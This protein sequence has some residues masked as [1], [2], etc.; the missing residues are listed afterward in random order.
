MRSVSK[1]L[2]FPLGGVAANAN[3]RD[4]TYPSE[5]SI[6]STPMAVNVIGEC[7]FSSRFR[8]G[9]RPGL[10]PLDSAPTITKSADW[11]W[12]N[13]ENIVIGGGS[14][15]EVDVDSL[16]PALPVGYEIKVTSVEIR[17]DAESSVFYE[18]YINGISAGEFESLGSLR[19]ETIIGT[20]F[21][22]G[23]D[24]TFGD[25]KLVTEASYDL[26][27]D[28]S[29]EYKMPDGRR[30]VDQHAALSVTAAKGA[31]PSTIS[32]F[33][34]YRDRF[35]V[36]NGNAWYASRVS[37]HD[38]FDYGGEGDDPTRAL[39][40]QIAQAGREG[41]EIT[42]LIPVADAQ[43]YVATARRFG[44]FSGELTQGLTLLSENTGVISRDAWCNA[45]G[46]VYFLGA[47][48]LYGVGESG[49]MNVSQAIPEAFKGVDSAVLVYDPKRNGIHIFAERGVVHIDYFYDIANKAFWPMSYAATKRPVSG[50]AAVIDGENVVVFKCA[51]GAWRKWSDSATS[52]DGSVLSSAVAIGPFKCGT[53][54]DVDG[55]L[56]A[57]TATMA[58]GSAAVGVE[59]Y[60]GKSAEDAYDKMLAA[61]NYDFH[62]SVNAGWNEKIYPRC[63][64]AWCVLKLASFGRWAYEAIKADIK[65][66][67]GLRNG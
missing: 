48:G 52:D 21:M 35:V 55:M 24:P 43:L 26:I 19:D 34:F 47:N 12:P 65:V 58:N 39:A 10:A 20:Y 37:V 31:I 6:Y 50:G 56:A 33:A 41:E 36:A 64:G 5:D 51:D 1:A 2:R 4:T 30:V 25:V 40:G 42:A 67:G 61:S 22:V 62:I 45:D 49:V 8:G 9:S 57:I 66:L 53:N 15:W 46:A 11:L 3:C 23:A 18:I 54:D 38:D 63:R 59:G 7:S 28:V 27:L 29:E 32:A 17:V 44:V 13:G 60:M 16:N 14:R